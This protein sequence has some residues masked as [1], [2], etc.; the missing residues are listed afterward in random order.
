M[1]TWQQLRRTSVTFTWNMPGANPHKAAKRAGHSVAMAESR[2]ADLVEVPKTAR[3]L[4]AAMQIQA[5]IKR[6][7]AAAKAR[8]SSIRGS[9]KSR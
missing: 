9:T 7:I 4:E 3:T 8:C 2:Y 6:V 5:E 1:F